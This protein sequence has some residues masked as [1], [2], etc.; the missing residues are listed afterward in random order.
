M[1]RRGRWTLKQEQDS[2]KLWDKAVPIVLG[3]LN[4]QHVKADEKAHVALEVIKK[5]A[6]VR[7]EP[8]QTPTG[9][10]PKFIFNIG[11][12]KSFEVDTATAMANAISPPEALNGR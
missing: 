12:G 9:P 7:A 2:Q 10:A 4:N 8:Q 3:Y 1:A 11:T 5:L 6:I